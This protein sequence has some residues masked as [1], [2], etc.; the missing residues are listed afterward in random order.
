MRI[1][2]AHVH[3]YPEEVNR[4][5]A[6]WAVR[7]GEAHWAVLCTRKRR[8]GHAVQGFPNVDELLRA[9]DA[10]GV[11]RAVLQGW[12]WEKHS[13][14]AWQNRFYAACIRAH[15]ERLS[16]FATLH[17][18]AGAAA[19]HE[20][21][22]RAQG[23]GFCGLGELSPHSQGVPPAEPVWDEIFSVAAERELPVT[24]HVTEPGG[25]SY[26]GKVAT[27]LA[28]YLR[29][30]RTHPR[31]TFILAHWGARFPLDAELGAH[32]RELPNVYYDTAASPLIY[33]PSIVDDMVRAIG[34]GR[35]LFGSDY[36]LVLYPKKHVTPTMTPFIA[37]LRQSGLPQNDLA[38]VFAGN[39]I[40]LLRL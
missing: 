24:L 16:A 38:A 15:P 19:V 39:A 35:V 5:P 12:Y 29:L 7:E 30:A 17:P 10:A 37:D 20:E 27:P 22:K 4:D 11:E 9:M 23:E 26:P 36:P 1:I 6:G 18:G 14:C 28:D 3:L 40:R 8:D 33:P 31:T 21:I 25:G 2:D 13:T 34:P 32:A